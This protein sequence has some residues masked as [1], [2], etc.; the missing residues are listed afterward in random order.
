MFAKQYLTVED[1]AARHRRSPRT[2]RDW[3]TQGCVTPH[4]RI[5]L[6]AVRAGKKYSIE[7]EISR[8]S[9]RA[10][11]TSPACRCSICL[12]DHPRPQE[13][14]MN[15]IAEAIRSH[16]AA[17]GTSMRALSLELGQGEKFIADIL[18]GKSKRPT[19]EALARLSAAIGVDLAALPVARQVISADMLRRLEDRPPEDWSPPKVSGAISAIRWLLISAEN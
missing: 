5:R 10:C 14:R 2:V 6:P 13:H 15:P 3:I 1:V 8:S 17:S 7:A 18:S 11:A 19:P 16:L 9:R 12:D 4:G